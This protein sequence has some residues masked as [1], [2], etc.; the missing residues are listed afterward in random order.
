LIRAVSEIAKTT[1]DIQLLLIGGDALKQVGLKLANDLNVSDM[2]TFHKFTTEIPEILSILD[3]YTLPSFWDGL[4]IG[5]LEAMAMQKA[6][7]ANSTDGSKEA[8]SDGKNGMLI[9]Y[10]DH[11]GL[12]NAILRLHQNPQ[13]R[14]VFGE[15]ARKTVEANYDLRTM[16][17]NNEMLYRELT[18]LMMQAA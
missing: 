9:P 15:S 17:R 16:V 2:I 4:P 8:I 18:P 1:R 12:A 11:Q 3:I 5:I 10:K 7:I 13:L 6:I 14:K